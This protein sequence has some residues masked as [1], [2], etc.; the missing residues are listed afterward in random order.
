MHR[1]LSGRPYLFVAEGKRNSTIDSQ[2]HDSSEQLMAGFYE[3]NVHSPTCY[4]RL[5]PQTQTSAQDLSGLQIVS[6]QTGMQ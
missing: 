2:D 5:F 4:S 3:I 1:A 6:A